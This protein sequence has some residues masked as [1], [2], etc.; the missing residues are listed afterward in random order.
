MKRKGREEEEEQEEKEEEEEKKE[1]GAKKVRNFVWK[2]WILVW[3]Y[4]FV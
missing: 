3:N 4:G 1:G 2:V